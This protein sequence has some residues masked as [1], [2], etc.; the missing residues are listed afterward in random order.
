M[1]CLF[2]R[3]GNDIIVGSTNGLLHQM[4]VDYPTTDR[5]VRRSDR[6]TDK[7][8]LDVLLQNSV[9]F[10]IKEKPLLRVEFHSTRANLPILY[11]PCPQ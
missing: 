10:C 4:I 5:D 1:K 6:S 8:P 11:T 3:G 7:V 2:P 9:D